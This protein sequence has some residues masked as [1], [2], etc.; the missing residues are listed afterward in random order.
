MSRRDVAELTERLG[1]IPSA[2]QFREFVTVRN[3]LAHLYPED[4]ARQAA[5]LNAAHAASPQLLQL[6][7]RLSD[8]V[9]AQ[10]RSRPRNGI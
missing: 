3:R 7:E 8:F 4:P 9:A 1:A 6:T 10:K 2:R 5:N